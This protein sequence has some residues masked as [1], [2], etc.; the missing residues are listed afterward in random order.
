[1]IQQET[2]KNPVLNQGPRATF[3]TYLKAATFTSTGKALRGE[4]SRSWGISP[5]LWVI[6]WLF[7]DF[8]G[9]PERGAHKGIPF[10]LGIC[11]LAC[12]SKVSQ[13][14]LSVFREQ[15]VGSCKIKP[16]HLL[17]SFAV[18]FCP[19]SFWER[20]HSLPSNITC[21]TRTGTRVRFWLDT[22]Q[23]QPT[24]RHGEDAPHIHTGQLPL[25][26][27]AQFNNST[28]RSYLP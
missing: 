24:P 19:L 25:R 9:H 20:V 26:R 10:Y 5:Y 18:L 21:S 14:H 11:Q 23:S 2:E 12:H 6:G 13:L 7:N 16:R 3:L 27:A 17:I 15:N 28:A 22:P 8:R 4:L 1:M